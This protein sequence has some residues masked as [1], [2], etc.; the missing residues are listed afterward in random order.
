M[1]Y[2]IWVCMHKS[3]CTKSVTASGHALRRFMH[4]NQMHYENFDCIPLYDKFWLDRPKILVLV[5]KGA[6]HY[7]INLSWE[8]LPKHFG[9]P[10]PIILVRM[11]QIYQSDKFGKR[12]SGPFHYKALQSNTKI[13]LEMEI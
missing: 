4:Y 10:K 8:G 3:L 7:I 12:S 2:A 9:L 6:F 5:G 11:T 13:S 1:H